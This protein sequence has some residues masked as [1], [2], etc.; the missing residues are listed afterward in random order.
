MNDQE[1]VILEQELALL[2]DQYERWRKIARE[3][4]E[5]LGEE[6]VAYW[7]DA[8]NTCIDLNSA[9]NRQ[10]PR[11]TLVHNLLIY[12]FLELYKELPWSWFLFL[13]GNYPMLARELRFTWEAFSQAYVVDVGFPT[14]DIERKI[15]RL[16]K[17]QYRGWPVILKALEIM[18]STIGEKQA[19]RG[20]YD[21]L[22][23]IAHPTRT[24]IDLK[25]L[26]A[27]GVPLLTDAFDEKTA[28][29]LFIAAKMLFDEVWTIAFF[30]YPDI[31]QPL[32]EV[33]GFVQHLKDF[34]P[35]AY[36][37][38]RVLVGKQEL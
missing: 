27:K 35:F 11:E 9:I 30:Q 20:R 24:E 23:L 3:T 25:L 34:C 16:N 22:S 31:A 28:S 15:K 36:L 1:G 7:V 10:Y 5:S 13:V 8:Y 12:R 2:D 37:H 19:W 6:S 33:S 14:I 32:S 38:L 26:R 29:G 18:P 4:I 17:K 21:T